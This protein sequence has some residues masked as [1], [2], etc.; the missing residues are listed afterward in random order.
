MQTGSPTPRKRRLTEKLQFHGDSGRNPGMLPL[1]QKPNVT[2]Q[3]RLFATHSGSA[4][5]GPNANLL[6]SHSLS[7]QQNLQ[8]HQDHGF[9]FS[10]PLG[11]AAP[12]I[13]GIKSE[14]RAQPE[15]QPPKSP[16]HKLNPAMRSISTPRKQLNFGQDTDMDVDSPFSKP[17][18]ALM[19]PLK[20]TQGNAGIPASPG[21]ALLAWTVLHRSTVHPNQR[22]LSHLKFSTPIHQLAE[23]PLECKPSP[24]YKPELYKA[25]PD[26]IVIVEDGI[27]MYL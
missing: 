6:R 15:N 18:H 21:A 7:D 3:Q 22:E 5:G 8:H 24:F 27:S 14:C 11:H 20:G 4:H 1:H 2:F 23:K 10:F 16:A 26:R 13:I 12:P 17:P 25:S 9:S 19:T